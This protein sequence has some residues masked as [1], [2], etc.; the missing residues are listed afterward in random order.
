MSGL[1]ESARLARLFGQRRLPLKAPHS[2]AR[3]F[4]STAAGNSQ[5]LKADQLADL[6]STTTYT[7]PAP[8]QESIDKFKTGTHRTNEERLPGGRYVQIIVIPRL[9]SEQACGSEIPKLIQSLLLHPQ[10]SISS[11]EILSRSS[12]SSTVTGII[13]S[14]GS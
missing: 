7:S 10:I 2:C 6:E 1:R 13:G 8:E 12:P 11:S 9:P 5:T 14:H 4:T 3:Q